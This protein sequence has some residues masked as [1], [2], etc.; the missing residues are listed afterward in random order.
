[1]IAFCKHC[2]ENIDYSKDPNHYHEPIR[3]RCQ[4]CGTICYSGLCVGCRQGISEPLMEEHEM[5]KARVR[6][7]REE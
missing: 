7:S 5:F 6:S 4:V 1:M 2:R 3:N